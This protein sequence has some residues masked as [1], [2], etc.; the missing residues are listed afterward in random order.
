VSRGTLDHSHLALPFTYR[1]F[2]CYGLPFQVVR[3][4]LT[5]LM[6]VRNPESVATFGLGSSQFARR[7]FGNLV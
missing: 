5:S 7:Y 6:L 4:G 1:A 3:L 2:T